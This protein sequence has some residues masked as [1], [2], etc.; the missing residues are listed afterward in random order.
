VGNESQNKFAAEPEFSSKHLGWEGLSLDFFSLPPVESGMIEVPEVVLHMQMDAPARLAM[1]ENGRVV[2]QTVYAGQFCLS[3]AGWYGKMLIEDPAKF[4]QLRMRPDFLSKAVDEKI[5]PR[6]VEMIT[7]RGIDDPQLSRICLALEYEAQ[8]RGESGKLFG[9]A[10]ATALAARLVA[11]YGATAFQIPQYRG[12]LPKYALR[13]ATDY[14]HANLDRDI[15]LSDLA[16]LTRM[17][18]YHFARL[19]RQTMGLAPHRYLV[20]QRIERAK[21]LLSDHT[22]TIAEVASALGFHSQSHFTSI[23]RRTTGYTPKQYR[24]AK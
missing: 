8:R 11:I 24:N 6:D 18:P 7:R 23:F 2:E 21:I 9:D 5:R 10:L 17:S 20:E 14:I 12:G 16:A 13:L 22:L 1:H 15:R 19:F 4:L 3:S